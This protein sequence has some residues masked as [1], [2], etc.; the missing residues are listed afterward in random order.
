MRLIGKVSKRRGRLKGELVIFCRQSKTFFGQIVYVSLNT[1]N[2]K[3]PLYLKIQ[4]FAKTLIEFFEK[5]EM[6]IF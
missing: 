5:C 4:R 1:L 6:Y 2:L 3:K